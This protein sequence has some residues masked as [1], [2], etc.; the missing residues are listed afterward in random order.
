MNEQCFLSL[1]GDGLKAYGGHSLPAGLLLRKPGHLPSP[2]FDASP[3]AGCLLQVSSFCIAASSSRI[4][5]AAG[6]IPLSPVLELEISS[7]SMS[8][9]E[10]VEVQRVLNPYSNM[11]S[12]G[13]V[14][15]LFVVDRWVRIRMQRVRQAG[16][17]AEA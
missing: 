11:L 2:P 7:D 17:T 4:L 9:D 14:R 13:R 10:Q 16:V 5:A 1:S 15:L 8:W 3:S 12:R 6:G